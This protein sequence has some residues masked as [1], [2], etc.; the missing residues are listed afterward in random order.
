MTLWR[1]TA[2]PRTAVWSHVKCVG[3]DYFCLCKHEKSLRTQLGHPPL[4]IL[5]KAAGI[6]LQA[7]LSPFIRPKTNVSTTLSVHISVLDFKCSPSQAPLPPVAWAK[8]PRPSHWELFV[9]GGWRAFP[10]LCSATR[11][12]YLCFPHKSA[13]PSILISAFHLSGALCP[14]RNKLPAIT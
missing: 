12:S 3:R 6:F 4:S 11:F 8:P 14:P 10:S 7:T 2:H 1:Q 9:N 13:S 5:Q